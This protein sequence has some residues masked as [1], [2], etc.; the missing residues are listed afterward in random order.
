MQHETALTITAEIVR[1]TVQHM[2][3]RA[4]LTVADVLRL[5]ATDAA[6]RARFSAYMQIA[7]DHVAAQ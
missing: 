1:D 6:A 7:R 5:L 4:G 3:D 2:A